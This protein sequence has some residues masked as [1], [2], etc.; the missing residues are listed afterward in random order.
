MQVRT[1]TGTRIGKRSKGLDRGKTPE[2]FI[3]CQEMKKLTKFSSP[4]FDIALARII[5]KPRYCQK[6]SEV[7][8]AKM[9]IDTKEGKTIKF[10]ILSDSIHLEVVPSSVSHSRLSDA[11]VNIQEASI[12]I[13]TFASQEEIR[14]TEYDMLGETVKIMWDD[15]SYLLMSKSGVEVRCPKITAKA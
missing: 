10:E 9:A 11:P 13:L 2:E 7:Y 12:P 14:Q 5:L 15:N 4:S 8:H 6:T 1:E 3:Q